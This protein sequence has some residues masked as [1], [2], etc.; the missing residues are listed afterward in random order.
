MVTG[1]F[2]ERGR[3][4]LQRGRKVGGHRDGHLRRLRRAPGGRQHAED[5][6]QCRPP[7]SRRHI[8]KDITERTS[9]Q[10][11]ARSGSEVSVCRRRR[12]GGPAAV[13]EPRF[14]RPTLVAAPFAAGPRPL[15]VDAIAS[16][17]GTAVVTVDRR[18]AARAGIRTQSDRPRR[19][20][21]G[22]WHR[23]GCWRLWRGWLHR[24]GSG[25]TGQEEE[26]K[27]CK[28][29]VVSHSVLLCIQPR[30][31]NTKS[32]LRPPHGGVLKWNDR[33]SR[34]DDLLVGEA[35]SPR[36]HNRLYRRRVRISRQ[37]AAIACRLATSMLR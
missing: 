6:G 28:R 29:P 5:Q 7:A 27:R 2:L 24:P 9:R 13:H 18:P 17:T 20:R 1:R 33:L 21:H 14:K 4:L 19:R 25:G 3:E 12:G 34:R 23:R 37:L 30:Y 31:S 10:I 11:R 36:R 15:G 26:E 8:R 32:P 22:D 35:A 16:W